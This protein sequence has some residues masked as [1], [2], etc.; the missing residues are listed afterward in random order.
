METRSNRRKTEPIVEKIRRG[1]VSVFVAVAEEMPEV[2]RM[3]V[4][5]KLMQRARI[6]PP[7]EIDNLVHGTPE[8]HPANPIKFRLVAAVKT[9]A[10]IF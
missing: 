3:H 10:V 9:H 6:N 2:F 4:V 7:F 8:W 1:E 5:P